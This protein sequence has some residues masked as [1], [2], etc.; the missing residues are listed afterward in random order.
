MSEK[1]VRVAVL[2]GGGS[3]DAISNLIT[4]GASSSSWGKAEIAEPPYSPESLCVQFQRS[5][6][7]R[8]CV[9]AYAVNID[10]H[11]H[12]FEPT[13]D[14]EGPDAADELAQ[15]LQIQRALS[16]GDEPSAE[17]I[18]RKLKEFRIE[19]RE[20]RLR[21]QTFFE[22]AGAT[23]TGKPISFPR[24]RRNTR[25][26]LETT[27]NAYW[28]VTRNRSGEIARFV[29]APSYSMRLGPL[30]EWVRVEE[31][32]RTSPIGIES[33]SRL[34]RFR[35]FVQQQGSKVVY[36][37]EFGDPRR[38]CAQDGRA[39]GKDE[40]LEQNETLANEIIHW[41]VHCPHS[42][43]G[44]PRWIG[45]LPSVVGSRSAEEVN[46]DYFENKAVPPLVL[47]VSGGRLSEE[48][49]TSLQDYINQE[50]K[51]KDNFHRILLIEAESGDTASESGNVRVDFKPLTDAQIKDE[52]FAK[53]DQR[54]ISKVG[55]SFRLPPILRGETPSTLNRATA[56]AAMRFAEEQVFDPERDD[57]DFAINALILGHMK[58]R[59]WR[60]RSNSTRTRDPERMS[61]MVER[62][63]KVGTFTPNE[64]RSLAGE[65]FN[66]QFGPVDADWARQPLSLS[67]AGFEPDRAAD[68][69]VEAILAG[70][71][72]ETRKDD[73]RRRVEQILAVRDLLDETLQSVEI[74]L[75][76]ETDADEIDA[77]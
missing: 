16:E 30:S 47:L 29:H 35:T 62:L 53:Y 24:L 42:S 10:G 45:N 58:I 69:D 64:M 32:V 48:A 14:L 3:Q 46:L 66:R 28:E 25:T 67:L 41:D 57:F 76:D 5:N 60:F 26:D 36:F 51:G 4:G 55:Q 15:A 61:E 71:P 1:G 59:F 43:Y 77:D 65:I 68:E 13:I 23:E 75:D 27:G 74:A 18:Q 39:L 2:K 9:D 56:L 8:Q 31:T 33:K 6:A 20:E 63:G 70:D 52:L 40:R 19:A 37:K 11:G 17:E 22:Q 44:A 7:L 54:N 72:E 49:V 73:L 38:I 34:R 50:I 12:H 21:L